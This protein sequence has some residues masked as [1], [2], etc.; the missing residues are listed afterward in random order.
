MIFFKNLTGFFFANSCH[1]AL[2]HQH[3]I[4]VVVYQLILA[5]LFCVLWLIF[6]KIYLLIR[7]S[8]AFLHWIVDKTRPR[9]N[10]DVPFWPVHFSNSR[11]TFF[12]SFH[13]LPFSHH[14]GG[15]FLWGNKKKKKKTKKRDDVGTR[16]VEQPRAS[17][18][19]GR[20]RFH[21]FFYLQ[22][23]NIGPGGERASERYNT[24]WG[25]ERWCCCIAAFWGMSRRFKVKCPAAL[26]ISFRSQQM[27]FV[28]KKKN[29]WLR[30]QK[31]SSPFLP[32]FQFPELRAHPQDRV[33]GI[34]FFCPCRAAREGSREEFLPW[35]FPYPSLF[36]L[37]R[38]A[39]GWKQ[40]R[41]M[42]ACFPFH[43]SGFVV[44]YTSVWFIY[45]I[46]FGTGY[47]RIWVEREQIR[48]QPPPRWYQVEVARGKTEVEKRDALL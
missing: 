23:T 7:F 21:L 29:S 13:S 47:T 37:A 2:I 28:S 48:M 15:S 24:L 40:K 16:K 4:Y 19:G 39:R 42:K 36:S 27:C 11:P 33:N 20:E 41:S 44:Y 5:L 45:L 43:L 18:G 25:S 1:R 22:A 8:L 10:N 3:N 9:W 46:L 32:L 14:W 30:S 35:G 31:V 34:Y 6:F 17:E 26:E 38:L 12:F